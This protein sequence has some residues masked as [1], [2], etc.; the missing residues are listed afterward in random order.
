MPRRIRPKNQQFHD[1]TK[2]QASANETHLSG[3]WIAIGSFVIG[4]MTAAASLW[5]AFGTPT[6][7]Q[8][9]ETLNQKTI[10]T[11][12]NEKLKAEN[13]S[14]QREINNNTKD[15]E[16]QKSI[17]NKLQLDKQKT[18]A[19]VSDLTEKKK[20]LEEKN[21]ALLENNNE[22]ESHSKGII[23]QSFFG[24]INHRLDMI[25]IIPMIPILVKGDK[26]EYSGIPILCAFP[27]KITNTCWRL[28]IGA[29][30]QISKEGINGKRIEAGNVRSV[31]LRDL[32]ESAF[33]KIGKSNPT[34]IDFVKEYR[35]KMHYHITNNREVFEI[36][37]TFRFTG[38]DMKAED[39]D[40]ER[41]RLFSILYK[42]TYA[43]K[44]KLNSMVH[45][46]VFKLFQYLGL[47]Q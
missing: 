20:N 40:K 35:K 9:A 23:F 45:A 22:L 39:A 28:T 42:D 33:E 37:L 34:G 30:G 10:I 36:P 21:N 47:R 17:V 7:Y 6:S 29:L 2:R 15:I 27:D 26:E 31:T 1:R 14:L 16:T 8:F 25:K 46:E 41:E 4:L 44:Y 11:L 5:I 19:E 43:G 13:K 32:V 18:E 38:L 24:E 12:E 3:K